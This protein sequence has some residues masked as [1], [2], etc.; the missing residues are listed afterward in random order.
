MELQGYFSFVLSDLLLNVGINTE[1]KNVIRTSSQRILFK[2]LWDKSQLIFNFLKVKTF[3]NFS[4]ETRSKKFSRDILYLHSFVWCYILWGSSMN[5]VFIIYFPALQHGRTL[6][7][8]VSVHESEEI[9]NFEN[10]LSD[11]LISYLNQITTNQKPQTKPH[12]T[13]KEWKVFWRIKR[14]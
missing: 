6:K 12:K 8:S 3:T 4:N 9:R 7:L 10:K 2:S 5:Q 13:M 14:T 1:R 11:H